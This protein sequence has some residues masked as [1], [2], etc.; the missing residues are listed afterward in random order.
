MSIKNVNGTSVECIY[1]FVNAV[2]SQ[3]YCKEIGALPSRPRVYFKCD[4][5]LALVVYTHFVTSV[6]VSIKR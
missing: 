1:C 2:N 3:I 6:C 5:D 4:N